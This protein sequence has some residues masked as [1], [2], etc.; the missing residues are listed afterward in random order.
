MRI[1]LKIQISHEP[2]DATLHNQVQICVQ[3][4]GRPRSSAKILL[5]LPLFYRHTLNT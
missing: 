3:M 1:K 4:V 2:S 5:H